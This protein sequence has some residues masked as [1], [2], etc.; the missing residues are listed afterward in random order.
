MKVMHVSLL[1]ERGGDKPLYDHVHSIYGC[2]DSGSGMWVDEI[3]RELDRGTFDG[4]DKEWMEK[5]VVQADL[6]QV[7]FIC[8]G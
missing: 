1:S 2:V 4:F 5:L 3:R 8:V 6:N 7:S